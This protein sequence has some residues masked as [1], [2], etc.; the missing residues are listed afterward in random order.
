[1][2]RL[3]GPDKQPVQN[4]VDVLNRLLTF[5]DGIILELGCGRAK[6]TRQVLKSTAVKK[7]IAAEV[8][9]TQHQKNLACQDLPT[10][11]FTRFGAEKIAA[12][13]QTFDV[14]LMFNSLHH[15]PTK[16]MGLALTEI[17]RVLKIDGFA[18]FSEP[19]F[20]GE[21]N[22]VMRLFHDESE[23]RI[24]AFNSLQHAV[25]HKL[26]QLEEE[27]FFKQIIC[28]ANFSQFENHVM[29]ATFAAHRLT[30]EL[31]EKVRNK[32]ERF[33]SSQGYVFEVPHRVDLLRRN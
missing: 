22:E 9:E 18:F 15:V 13:D 32:F 6:K 28:F 14:V 24:A 4:D 25:E 10:I 27:I 1:M 2:M 8:D 7:I 30:P 33:R 19:V 11:E 31:H 17:H 12:W 3:K 29:N 5:D 20:A 16:L 26:F 23:V 21:L